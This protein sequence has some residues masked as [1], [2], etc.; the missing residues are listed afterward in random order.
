MKASQLDALPDDR[1]FRDYVDEVI[2]DGDL[3][4]V[5]SCGH[6]HVAQNDENASPVTPQACA[7]CTAELRKGRP[8]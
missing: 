6:A 8:S 1:V 5:L 7:R 2:V 4:H 3:F